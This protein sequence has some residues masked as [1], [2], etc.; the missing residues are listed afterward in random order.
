VQRRA[1]KIPISLKDLTYDER[2]RKLN[3]TTLIYRRQRTDILQVFR[4]IKGFDKIDPNFFFKFDRNTI[5]RGHNFKIFKPRTSS[6]ARQHSFSFR[7][8]NIWN[9]L[10]EETVSCETINSFKTKLEKEWKN[11]PKKFDPSGF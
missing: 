3:L 7:V 11:H 8:I 6:R 4:I 2:L 1:T 9:A 5:T 10:S